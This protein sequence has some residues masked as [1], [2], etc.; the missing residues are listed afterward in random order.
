MENKS[1]VEFLIN[2]IKQDQNK[3]PKGHVEWITIF[4][5]ARLIEAEQFAWIMTNESKNRMINYERILLVLSGITIG[6]LIF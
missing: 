5:K 3:R 6:Y 4:T 2:E 1:G